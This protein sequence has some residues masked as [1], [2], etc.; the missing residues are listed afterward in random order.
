[1][2]CKCTCTCIFFFARWV[3]IWEGLI[4]SLINALDFIHILF[5]LKL[6]IAAEWWEKNRIT[7]TLFFFSDLA[8]QMIS[9][10]TPEIDTQTEIT[11]ESTSFENEV[12]LISWHILVHVFAFMELLSLK[13][14]HQASG[15][16]SNLWIKCKIVHRLNVPGLTTSTKVNC[17]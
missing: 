8:D 16:W 9:N 3:L 7:I 5:S 11:S 10:S 2:F 17:Y 15:S 1:M 13:S 6:F 4:Q 12:G 14:R